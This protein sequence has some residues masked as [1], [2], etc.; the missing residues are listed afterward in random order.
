MPHD[1]AYPAGK[2]H[3][4]RVYFVTCDDCGAVSADL[5]ACTTRADAEKAKRA[6]VRE[7]HSLA[8]KREA[9]G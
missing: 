3:I 4:A 5:A 8:R 2:V 7:F 9:D 1:R 6:H